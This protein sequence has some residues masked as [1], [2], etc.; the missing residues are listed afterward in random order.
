M[1]YV[2]FMFSNY[3]TSPEEGTYK[4]EAD[5]SVQVPLTE[6]SQ[7]NF[8]TYDGKNALLYQIV[9]YGTDHEEIVNLKPFNPD[10][11]NLSTKSVT[12]EPGER[13]CAA[14]IEVD[15]K[16]QMYPCSIDFLVYDTV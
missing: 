3:Y 11:H 15:M 7:I 4:R 8:N 9:I 6:V 14:R 10:G 16:Y 13:I 5:K 12:V 1:W 2:S